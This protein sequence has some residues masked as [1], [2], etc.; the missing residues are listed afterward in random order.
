MKNLLA[1]AFV[2]LMCA[3]CFAE[4]VSEIGYKIIFEGVQGEAG[5]TLTENGDRIF[6][7]D[8]LINND[9]TGKSFDRKTDIENEGMDI[10]W[11]K[12]NKMNIWG[13]KSESGIG[14]NIPSIEFYFKKGSQEKNLSDTRGRHGP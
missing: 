11:N 12:V 7:R 14:D 10:L 2:C 9:D 1:F 3:T 8:Y 6:I 13:L 5:I 4:T